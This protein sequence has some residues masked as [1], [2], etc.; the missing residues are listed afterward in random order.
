MSEDPPGITPASDILDLMGRVVALLTDI[1]DRLAAIE[2]ELKR[3]G[4]EL[5]A[6]RWRE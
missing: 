3:Q 2:S 4:D 1:A 5:L 6:T